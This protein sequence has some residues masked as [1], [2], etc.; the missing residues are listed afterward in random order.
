[1]TKTNHKT[2]ILLCAALTAIAAFWLTLDTGSTRAQSTELIQNGAMESYYGIGG[3]NVVP[4]GW[5]YQSNPAGVSTSK[6]QWQYE[7]QSFVGSWHIS[8][9]YV[10]FGMTGYQFVPGVRNGTPLRFSAAAQLYTCNSQDSCI[11]GSGQRV[12]DRSSGAKV[13]VGIDPNGGQNPDAASLVWSAWAQPFDAFQTL[14]VDSKSA[15]D[16][17]VTVFVQY[18][19]TQGLFL[20][21]VFW[22]NASMVA[23]GPVT[24]G[25]PG[26]SAPG[27][28]PIATVQLSVPYVTPQGAQADGSIVHTVAAGD[29]LNSI[30]VAYKVT[31]KQ[32]RELNNMAEGFS[33]I[34]IGQKLVIKKSGVIYVIVTATPTPIT[35]GVGAVVSPAATQQII[36][37]TATPSSTLSVTGTGTRVIGQ[38]D[39]PAVSSVRGLKKSDSDFF[40]AAR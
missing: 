35:E 24:P 11:N 33:I 38:S 30:A 19:Q 7:N 4:L 28:T 8:T 27:T 36:V 15:N 32:I 39:S 17:G 34:Q 20:N 2:L 22:D 5:Q 23:S 6:Q 26:T 25:T 16:N 12:S 14:T 13:R 9:Q 29:T 18:V 10:L 21:N 40:G 31:V 37:I 3:S 1:M